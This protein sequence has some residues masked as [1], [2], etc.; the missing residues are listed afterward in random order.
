MA[1]QT[2]SSTLAS[3]LPLYGV[4]ALFGVATVYFL[5]LAIRCGWVSADEAPKYRMLEEETEGGNHGGKE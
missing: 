1:D 5:W 3:T 4:M 2:F